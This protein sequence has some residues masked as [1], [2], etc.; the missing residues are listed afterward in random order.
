VLSR[1]LLKTIG[2]G[3]DNELFVLLVDLLELG[4]DLGPLLKAVRVAL[5]RHHQ[6]LLICPWPP[7]VPPPT[8]DQ[9]PLQKPDAPPS[10]PPSTALGL[11]PILNETTTR[12]YQLAYQKARQA[13][14]RLGVQVVS[15][16]MG[17]PVALVLDR[18]DRL[19]LVGRRRR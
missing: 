18:M 14:A 12:H 7:G 16:V 2:K 8:R 6:V 3:R 5:A 17:E 9:A 13:F 15:A 19:R 10:V 4:D 11:L 1:A